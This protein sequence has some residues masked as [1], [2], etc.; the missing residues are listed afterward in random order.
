MSR[1]GFS[2]RISM[3]SLVAVDEFEQIGKESVGSVLDLVE[4]RG[5]TAEGVVGVFA[6]GDSVFVVVVAERL[7]ISRFCCEAVDFV[8][9]P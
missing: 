1:W 4:D 8:S 5:D 7:Y 9:A 2:S 6:G 3:L